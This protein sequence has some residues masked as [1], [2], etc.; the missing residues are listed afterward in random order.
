V[1]GLGHFELAADDRSLFGL[2]DF[3]GHVWQWCADTYR[4]HPAY[5]GGDVNSNAYFLRVTVRPLEAAEHCGHLVGFRVVRDLDVQDLQPPLGP[6][7]A[8]APQ[9]TPPTRTEEE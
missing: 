1:A 8:A 9:Q 4:D 3:T 2:A 7:H 5:R 6:E